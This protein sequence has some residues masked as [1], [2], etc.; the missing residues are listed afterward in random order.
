MKNRV[1]KFFAVIIISLICISLLNYSYAG[2]PCTPFASL[3]PSNPQP[4]DE[5]TIDFSFT[6]I[7][8][9]VTSISF[10]LKYEH[11]KFEYVDAIATD[12]WN[13]SVIEDNFFISSKNNEATTTTGKFATIK[14][15]VKDNAVASTETIEWKDIDV[16]FDDRSSYKFEKEYEK[17][18]TVTIQQKNG[19]QNENTSGGNTN[20]S[21][22]DNNTPGGNTS[23]S[24]GS[25]IGNTN[26]GRS[27]DSID[28][29]KIVT[30]N[31]NSS[32]AG[33]TKGS[34]AST[35]TKTLPKTGRST[36]ITLGI[37][38]ATLGI[39]FSYVWYRK[40]KNI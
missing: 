8:D 26:G 14:L 31:G 38:L 27:S 3:K 9:P 34:D 24:G 17:D 40:Y 5:I 33:S 20:T 29:S 36:I 1:I 21:G 15:K 28:E 25:P 2:S 12:F 39:A 37:V 16:G 23:N 4:G 30:I 19:T 18:W 6:N 11:E 7:H 35:T 22:G 13:I 10:Y 32:N